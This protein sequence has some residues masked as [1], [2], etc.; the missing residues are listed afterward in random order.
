MKDNDEAQTQ[1][2]KARRSTQSETD[3]YLITKGSTAIEMVVL[4]PL[5][6]CSFFRRLNSGARWIVRLGVRGLLEENESA[7]EPK[8]GTLGE[9]LED[10]SSTE[11]ILQMLTTLERA[12]LSWVPCTTAALTLRL[13]ELDACIFYTST[14]LKL[15]QTKH[16]P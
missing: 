2:K 7:P 15:Q 9:K 14:K 13:M 10:S 8:A 3:I 12:V 4:D 6:E 11:D 1:K 5:S 16:D